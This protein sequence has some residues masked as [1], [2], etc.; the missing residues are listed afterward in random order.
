MAGFAGFITERINL[1]VKRGIL[2]LI[3]SIIA[4]KSLLCQ[5]RSILM[6]RRENLHFVSY[7]IH[8]E[9]ARRH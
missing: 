1:A 4:V 9:V 6:L 7:A 8:S 2:R 3:A 5:V